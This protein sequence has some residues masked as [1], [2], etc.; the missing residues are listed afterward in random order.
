[1]SLYELHADRLEPI[2]HTSFHTEQVSE[3][4]H[5][6]R[7]LRDQIHVVASDTL[8]LAEEF[9]DWDDSRRR[10]DLLCLDRK[11]NLVVVE[12]KA[13]EDGGH[14]E[15][16]ALRYAAMVSTL[17]FD[18]A[19]RA[20][21]RYLQRRGNTAD[22]R[23]SILDFLG[24]EAEGQGRFA[25]DVR[26][27]LVSADFSRELT[28]AVLWLNERALNI[29]C[30]RI[31]PHRLN[32]SVILDVQQIV[33]LPEAAEYQV[34]VRAKEQEE[35]T[36]REAVPELREIWNELTKARSAEE[37][38]LARAVE[39][40]FLSV[41]ARTFPLRRG[42]GFS[43][44][45]PGEAVCWLGKI[46]TSG[47]VQVWFQYLANHK[48][49]ADEAARHLLRERLNQIPGV[50]IP[51][52]RISGKPSFPLV[53]LRGQEAFMA[54]AA[55]WMGVVELLSAPP[56]LDDATNPAEQN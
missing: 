52:E 34:R 46:T 6:Q 23:Q 53:A 32:G 55:A 41:G 16:Q 4:Y 21:Y 12:L 54:F 3:R 48:V 47:Q 14:M 26:I 29:Q 15:L 8:V 27:V 50:E 40:W 2:P 19:V 39:Q 17:T 9:G 30:I 44:T 31:R 22:P 24:W 35:R 20:H 10:I 33:P 45:A 28:T 25:A 1:M 56:S 11:A 5:L 13:T 51:P 37:V 36:A 7:L 42:I 49:F 43:Y 18:D 38:E